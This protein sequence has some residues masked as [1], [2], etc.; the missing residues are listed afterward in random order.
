MEFFVNLIGNSQHKWS[1]CFGIFFICF[2]CFLFCFSVLNISMPVYFA[3]EMWNIV[4][5]L[6]TYKTPSHFG[7]DGHAHR[8]VICRPAVYMCCIYSETKLTQTKLL[9]FQCHSRCHSCVSFGIDATKNILKTSLD[10][11]NVTGWGAEAQ[12]LHCQR[13]F[14]SWKP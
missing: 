1:K 14:G 4:C 3:L 5:R 2:V 11:W 12:G 13:K 7:K 8:V 9:D 6:A 10:L